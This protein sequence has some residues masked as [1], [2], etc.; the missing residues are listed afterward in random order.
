MSP[1]TAWWRNGRL[2]RLNRLG[3]LDRFGE[4]PG[5]RDLRAFH[6]VHKFHKGR[7]WLTNGVLLLLGAALLALARQFVAESVHFT[8]GM[9]GV[10]GWAVFVYAASVLVVLT[11]PANRWTLAIIVSVSVACYAMVYFDDPFSSSDIYRYVW[12][13]MVQHEGIN[14]YR[15]V[16]GDKA[17][18]YLRAP[19][20]DIFDNIN[21][22]DYARTIYPPVAQL[23]Y[24]VVTFFSPTVAAMKLAMI[25]F[26]FGGGVVLLRL[27]V[28]MGRPREDILLYAWCPPLI[29]ELGLAGHVDAAVIAFVALAL[30]F[31]YQNKAVWTGLFLGLAILTKFYPAVLFPALWMRRDWKM[32][33]VIAGLAAVT[34]SVYLSAGKYVLGFMGGYEKEEGLDSGQRFFLLS[35][36]H[37]VPGLDSVPLAVYLL[38][39]VAVFGALIGW[40]WRSATVERVRLA[41]PDAPGT[42]SIPGISGTPAFLHVATA[43]AFAMM[44]LFAPHYP[45]YV[46]W[47]VPFFTLLPDLPLMAYVMTMFYLLWTALAD[48][49]APKMYML[50]ERLYAVV[51][52][53]FVLQASVK[54]WPVLRQLGLQRDGAGSSAGLGGRDAA[55]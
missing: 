12:D 18:T 55:L 25:G 44:L 37:H 15:Y 43:L 20:Q 34:Y 26:L 27:L 45:W 10:A 3:R 29:W 47:L 13:G 41:L 38:F 1:G 40:A 2:G 9:S 39:C 7:P 24:Y 19:N 53:A 6:D 4:L 35:L 32:P 8:L 49:T 21:R 22:R 17:L 31:R 28:A 54:R 50:N 11:Q 36:L 5:R 42:A 23:I 52:V 46:V 14:P 30:W 51:A 48:G 33:A 16:P